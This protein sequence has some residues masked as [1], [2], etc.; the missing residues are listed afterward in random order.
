MGEVKR[1]R[2]TCSYRI[3]IFKTRF[4]KEVRALKLEDALE[5]LYS[6]VG[7][8]HRVKRRNIRVEKVDVNGDG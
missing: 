6:E 8:H 4:S 2:I 1:F 7:S 3:G 5:K